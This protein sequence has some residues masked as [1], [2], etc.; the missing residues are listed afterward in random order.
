MNKAHR[1]M[2]PIDRRQSSSSILRRRLAAAVLAAASALAVPAVANAMMLVHSK[3]AAGASTTPTT[4]AQNSDSLGITI[5]EPAT[6]A[7]QSSSP[8]K[9]ST[10]TT[11]SAACAKASN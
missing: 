6:P 4:Q 5:Y 9:A 8:T 7:G 10:S 3:C 1:P 2:R 11:Q